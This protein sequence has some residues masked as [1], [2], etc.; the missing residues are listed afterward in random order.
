MP[1]LSRRSTGILSVVAVI[2]V[3]ATAAL[4]ASH[5][6]SAH[7]HPAAQTAA[8]PAAQTAAQTAGSTAGAGGA[9]RL[10]VSARA[11]GR[12]I[13]AGFL[14]LSLEYPAVEAYAGS[15]PKAINPVLVQLIRNLA[16][17]QVPSLRIGGDTTDWTWWPV[18]GV[19]KPGGVKYSLGPTWARVTGALA[20]ELG[21]RVILGINLEAD[22]RTIAGAEARAL[23]AGLGRSSVQAFELGNEPELYGSF[24]WYTTGSGLHVKGRPPGYD[25]SAFQGDFSRIGD[26][27]PSMPLAGPATGAPKWIPQLG[28]FL[29]AHPQ[30]RVATL[31]RYPV[32]QCFVAPA[33]PVYPSVAHLLAPGASRGLADSVAPF[34]GVAH[35]HHASLRIDEMNTVSCGD[36][37]GVSNAFVSG[38][39]VLDA[40]FQMARV[41][42]DGVNIHTYPGAPYELFTFTRRSGRWRGFVAPQYYGLEM[43]AQAVPP[44]ARLLSLSGS[45]G[46]VKAWATRAPDGTIHVV[47]IN[48]Y[49]AQSRTVAV[50]IAGAQG[51]ARLER[52]RAK[53]ISATTGVTLG[54]QTFGTE[55]NTGTLAGR[56]TIASVPK[57][58]G[59]YV[60]RVPRAS[61]AMLTLAAPPPP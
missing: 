19:A 42:V 21:A 48:E 24:T 52:L 20:H 31:H 57:S 41:G 53:G 22:S 2:A 60:V 7:E 17:N 29:P 59:A 10:Q 43:F 58:N 47:L 40:V 4:I 32:Q 23:L 45:L 37:P 5:R 9:E 49:T 3:A 55:T 11:T 36:A 1:R 56:S 50:R 13:P 16:P 28:N 33:S 54:G 27:L 18:A 38:L 6:T 30:V 26:A 34:V 46:K 12:P 44:G 61:A 14:G 39:W 25:F 15:D 51:P 8:H 35:A